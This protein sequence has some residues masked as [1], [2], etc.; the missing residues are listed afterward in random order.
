MSITERTDDD[1]NLQSL[2]PGNPAHSFSPKC[3]DAAIS[4]VDRMQKRTPLS[5][6]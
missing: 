5:T 2:G 1:R 6:A 4:G 3:L